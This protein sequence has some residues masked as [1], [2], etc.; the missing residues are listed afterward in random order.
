MKIKAFICFSLIFA[1]FASAQLRERTPISEDVQFIM[2][3]QRAQQLAELAGVLALSGEQVAALQQMKGELDAIKADAQAQGETAKTALDETAAAIRAS[4]ENGGELTEANQ[5]ALQAHFQE[6]R[7]I[8]QAARE[9]SAAATEGIGEVLS[10]EQA[11]ALRDW[12]RARRP[13]AGEGEDE[14]E[15]GAV[16]G[17][18]RQ[19]AGTGGRGGRGARRGAPGAGGEG[20]SQLDRFEQGR[21]RILARILLSD[22][23]L[24]NF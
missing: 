5:S 4:L 24:S 18:A 23:F 1:S 12:M 15:G 14:G 16:I 21:Q 13:D 9:A 7:G 8:R 11:Q 22:A 17:K 10:E 6:L 20:P 19:D 2:E 3:W